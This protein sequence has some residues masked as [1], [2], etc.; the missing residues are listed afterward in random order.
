MR[1]FLTFILPAVFLSIP[2]CAQE[3]YDKWEYRMYAGYNLGGSSPLPLPAEIRSINSWNPGFAWTLGIQATRRLAPEWGVTAGLAIDVK[4]MNI[5]ADVKYMNTDLDIG[6]GINQ[7]H[8]S[9]MF[10]GKNSTSV[11][12]G[13]LLIPVMATYLP[14]AEPS[15]RFHIGGY[16]AFLRDANFEGTA[17][18]GY[19]RNGGP[20]GDRIE[21]S[22][23]KFDFSD[24]L[25]KVDA[26]LMAAANCFLTPHIGI[27]G[28]LSWGLLPLFPSGCTGIPYK[29]YNIYFSGGLAYRL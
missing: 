8:F 27:Q 12:N 9:G 1:Y 18:D 28:Q 17:S 4:G 20:A 19:I 11:K 23:A 21:V 25:R 3:T 15:W 24:R 16:V 5:E 26:G 14:S 10:T 13:Y 7:G 22:E 2:L 6:E 29:L